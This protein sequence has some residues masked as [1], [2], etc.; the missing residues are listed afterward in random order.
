MI[1]AECAGMSEVERAATK[2]RVKKGITRI[3][4][5][6]V[7]QIFGIFSPRYTPRAAPAPTNL[8]S[9]ENEFQQQFL[10]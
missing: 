8:E 1:D 7:P 3:Q 5:L 10:A 6:T 4:R 2:A 9:F